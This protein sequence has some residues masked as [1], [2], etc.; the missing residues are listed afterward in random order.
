MNALAL[1]ALIIS[2][3]A[4]VVAFFQAVLAYFS[5]SSSRQRCTRA[6][7]GPSASLGKIRWDF[8]WWRLR[9]Y[10]PIVSLRAPDLLKEQVRLYRDSIKAFDKRLGNLAKERNWYWCDVNVYDQLK[11]YHVA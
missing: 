8:R 1:A 3:F 4:F 2:V 5:T 10:Y 6:A 9:V 7:I 11:W